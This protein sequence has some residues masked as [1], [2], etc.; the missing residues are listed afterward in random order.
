MIDVYHCPKCSRLLKCAGMVSVDG[1]ELPVFSC[2]DCIVRKSI[3][4]AGTEEFDLAYTF[5]VDAAGRYFDPT[6]SLFESQDG[7]D[8]DEDFG[9]D[10]SLN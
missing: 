9:H 2:E 3:F 5:C 1:H 10:A 8:D 6:D 4:E 7:A